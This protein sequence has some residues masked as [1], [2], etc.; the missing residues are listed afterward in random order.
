LLQIFFFSLAPTDAQQQ[1]ERRARERSAAP[2]SASQRLSTQSNTGAIRKRP[3]LVLLIV[4]DQFRYDYFERFGDLFVAGGLKRLMR[5]GAFWTNVNYDHMPTFTAP[6]H[7]TMMTGAWPAESGIVANEWPDRESGTRVTSVSDENAVL[8]GGAQG[9]AA[10]SP[11]RL[12]ASTVGDELRLATHDR[13]KVIGISAKDRSAILPAGRHASAAYWFSEQTGRMVTSNFYYNKLPAWV[14]SFNAAH[15]TDDYFG[16]KWERLLP[17]EAEY[18]RRAGADAP[19]WETL[20]GD[21][22]GRDTNTFPHVVTGGASA[23]GKDFYRFGFEN[24][25]FSNDQLVSFTEQAITSENLGADDDTDVLTV[26]FSANDYVGHRFGPYSQEMMDVT[27]RVDRQISALLDFVNGRVGLQNTLVAFTA[28][29][30]VAPIP[31]HAAALGLPGGRI[32]AVDVARAIRL[33]I[34]ARY[35]PKNDQPDRTADYIFK[36]REG[37]AFKDAFYN[38]NLYFNPVALKRDG[39]NQEEIERIAG[40]AAMTVPGVRGYFTRTQLQ[41]GAV[42]PADPLAR[43]VLHGFYARRS[44]DVI[45]MYDPFKKIFDYAL[46]SDHGSPYS[47]DTHVPLIIMGAGSFKP[48]RYIEAATPADLAPTLSAVLDI[49]APS[50]NVGRVLTEALVSDRSP[51]L[52]VGR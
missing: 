44:G 34:K 42:S 13:S 46:A 52:T 14:D 3:R 23:P 2:P 8:L 49:Q 1:Q 11:R 20:R 29:H 7:A 35:N 36:Y 24:S 32:E 40:E 21:A 25:P 10:A 17:D 6:G 45:V 48:G 41:R 16:R 47:Y 50:N 9:E 31:E 37:N 15:P 18:L 26:S 38:G 28:D 4:V 33:A 12:M 19:P 30:G 27:L 5:D 43:R 51:A 39:I 22:E